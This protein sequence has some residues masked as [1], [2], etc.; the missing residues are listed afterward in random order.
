[1]ENEPHMSLVNGEYRVHDTLEEARQFEIENHPDHFTHWHRSEKK[2]ALVMP[3][4]L[5]LAVIGF[6]MS[7]PLIGTLLVFKFS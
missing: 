6:A 3:I 7:L 4:L 1:M 2:M 5:R